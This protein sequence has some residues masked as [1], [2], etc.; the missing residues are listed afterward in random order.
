MNTKHQLFCQEKPAGRCTNISTFSEVL[1]SIFL[2]LIFPFSLALMIE[3]ISVVV[4]V[5]NGNSVIFRVFL[6]SIEI[7]ALTLTLP[8]LLP[9][10]MR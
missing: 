5:A 10:Y 6:S 2:I 4:V 7:L 8:P 1:S 3:L 9:H